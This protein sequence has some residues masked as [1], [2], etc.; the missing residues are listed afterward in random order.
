MA[1]TSVVT[2]VT[3]YQAGVD[4]LKTNNARIMAFFERKA[5]QAT[6]SLQGTQSDGIAA[7]Y[8]PDDARDF[9]AAI[10][11]LC[12]DMKTNFDDLANDLMGTTTAV[13]KKAKS[14]DGQF[15]RVEKVDYQTAEQKV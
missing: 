1:N 13:T 7:G 10:E 12:I 8:L 11:D 5:A 6:A 4:E 15:E 2:A 3:M 9:I 14:A